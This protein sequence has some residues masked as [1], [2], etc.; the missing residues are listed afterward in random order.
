MADA[1]RTVFISWTENT[2]YSYEDDLPTVAKTLGISTAKLKKAM[3]GDEELDLSE[4]SAAAMKRL[5]AAAS[6]DSE[7][8]SVEEVTET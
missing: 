3:A 6:L 2:E 1:D 7:E 4:L 8:L 5:R